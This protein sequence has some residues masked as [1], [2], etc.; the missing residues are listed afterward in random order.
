MLF[1]VTLIDAGEEQ[2]AK[3]GQG[4]QLSDARIGLIRVRL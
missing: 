4:A 1:H 2:G 3:L